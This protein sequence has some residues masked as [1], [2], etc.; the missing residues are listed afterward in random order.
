MDETQLFK[1]L[2]I[3]TWRQIRSVKISFHDRLTILTGANG[4]GKTTIL[5]LISGHFGW[6]IPLVATPVRD[7]K[8]GILRY[9]SDYWY[10]KN[11]LYRSIVSYIRDV[12]PGIQ[13]PSR[14]IIGEIVYSDGK[15]ASLSIPTDDQTFVIGIA[16]QNPV[17]GL[18]IPSHRPVYTY[19]Q[20]GT[21]PTQPITRQQAF[22]N[23]RNQVQ[24][25]Y[26]GQGSMRNVN[27]VIKETLLSLATFGPGN[28]F[29]NSNNQ[30]T[31]LFTQFQEI[32]RKVLPPK[33]G[34]ERIRIEVPEVMLVTRSGNFPLDGVSG[35]VASIIDMAW[36]IFMFSE[37]RSR[38][39]VTIDEP[40]NH[41]HPELQQTILVG[42][43]DAFP[44]VQFIIATHNPFII[45]SVPDSNVYV[46]D[47]NEDRAVESKFLD[48]V[49]KSGTANEIL[50]DVLGL[51]FTMPIWAERRVES[52][53]RRHAQVQPTEGSLRELREELAS[54]GL[55][56]LVPEAIAKVLEDVNR[57]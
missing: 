49:N 12:S 44:S 27:F 35:G 22:D 51:P 39:V 30:A 41:L 17:R 5:N 6:S 20:V 29:V 34:F 14:H 48:F 40:E 28:E 57:E 55:E 11:N 50:R 7:K 21:I 46:L 8:S 24:Q 4:T 19:Q 25:R 52:I 10:S 1:S 31:H 36:Q 53:I 32:L 54:I 56:K 18:H 3:H 13:P 16:P 43:L 38:F 37:D 26:M 42:L 15:I 9:V 47:Y 23:Y 2:E 45:S 33:L